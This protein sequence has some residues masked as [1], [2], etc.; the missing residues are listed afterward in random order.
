MENHSRGKVQ[1]NMELGLRNRRILLVGGTRGL[2]GAI[3][4]AFSNEGARIALCAR[5]LSHVKSTV[6]KLRTVGAEVYGDALDVRDVE[7]LCA[8]I[9][10]S[11]TTL[12]GADAFIWNVS[13]QSRDWDACLDIDI[14]SC[15]A[16]VEAVIPALTRSECGSIVC[17]ASRAASLGV[18]SYAPYSAVKAALLSYVTSLSR[19][20]APQVRVNA[21]S[22]G[23]IFSEDGFWGRMRREE[24]AMFAATVLRNPMGRLATPD[25]VAQAVVFLASSA[26]G[27][28][29]GANLR[30]DGASSEHVQL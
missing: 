5:N 13:A 22:P 24:P 15:V 11:I 2:G 30:V 14:R 8:W 27:F 12:G 9:A 16:G 17:V 18:P 21:V 4:T 20:V 28:I 6:M 26:A 19:R 10:R 25:E 3:A 1:S 7:S 29:S 23:E